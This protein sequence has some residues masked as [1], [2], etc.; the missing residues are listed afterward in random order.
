MK[1][2]SIGAGNVATHLMEALYRSG[3][4]IMQI[5]SRT[6]ESATVLADKVEA[7]PINSI[8]A[9]D[10][11]ADFYIFSVSDDALLGLIKQ[12]PRTRGVWVHTSGSISVDIFAR[13]HH[14]YGVIYPLQTFS[15]QRSLYFNSIP[16][17][18]EANN[19]DVTKEIMLLAQTISRKIEELPSHKR[20]YL[21]L[22]GVM[23]CNF[24]NYM[25]AEAE[26]ILKEQGMPFEVLLPLISETAHKVEFLS[27]IEAQTG[28]ALRNDELTMQKHI[29]LLED[30]ELKEIYKLLSHRI[31]KTRL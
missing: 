21:H 10:K 8:A 14:K 7:M 12:M 15:K 9:M 1:I 24:V 22:C 27:P 28:P 18:I 13:Y 31:Y 6:I 17:F 16:L 11:D 4:R 25:Y 3:C 30:D 20:H 23:T 2:I 29:N 26:R 5:Y 19:A